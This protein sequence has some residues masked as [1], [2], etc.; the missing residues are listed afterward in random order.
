VIDI[1]ARSSDTDLYSDTAL[2]NFEETT[3]KKLLAATVL[4]ALAIVTTTSLT[5]AADNDNPKTTTKQVMKRALKGPLTKKVATGK[6]S[7]AEKKE[8]LELFQAMAKNDP[9]K[10]DKNSWKEKNAA[11]VKA[12]TAAVKGD[13]DAGAALMKAANCK[14]CHSKHKPSKQ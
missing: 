5:R 4:L 7:D 12:A 14:T 13:S 11:L 1:D 9:P 8:L 6:A 2:S 10:G 3:M